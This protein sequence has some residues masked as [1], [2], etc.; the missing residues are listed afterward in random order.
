[1]FRRKGEDK[2][3]RFMRKRVMWLPIFLLALASFLFAQEHRASGIVLSTDATHRSLTISCAAIPGYMDAM[4]MPFTVRDAKSLAGLKPGTAVGFT[5]VEREK[6]LYAE[7]IQVRS[8]ANLES[9]P[10]QAGQL[11]ALHN[12][13]DP[14]AAASVLA[15]GQ[16]VPDFQL[17]DQAAQPIRLSQFHG[18]AV[19]LTFGYSRCPNPNYCLRLSNNLASVERRFQSRAGR[20]FVLLTIAID[21]EHDQGAALT[22]YADTWK[23]NPAV[24]HFLTGPLS[25]IHRV[26][27]MFG[28][29]FWSDDGLITHSLHTVIIDREGQLVVNLNGN[30]FTAKQFGDLLQSVMDRK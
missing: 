12:A 30:A 18:K 26:S 4:E 29:N 22:K 5:I 24:W 19:A 10:L 7:T 28:M 25:E 9:E 6:K 1:M 8:D 27:G 17:T 23:A 20:D 2:E 11:T 15:I 21:P 3:D 13:V 14:A 16:H